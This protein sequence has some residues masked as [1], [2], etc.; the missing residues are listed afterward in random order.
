M[1]NLQVKNLPDDL[2]AALRSRAEREGTSLS[3]LVTRLL[4]RE[5]SLPSMTEWLAEVA[6]LPRLGTDLDMANVIDAVRAEP[7]PARDAGR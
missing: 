7:D 3:E 2:H 4:R 5:L 6:A 1:A